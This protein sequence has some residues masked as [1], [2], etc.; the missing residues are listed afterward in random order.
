MNLLTS[1][2]DGFFK[3]LFFLFQKIN[4][5]F[6]KKQKNIWPFNAISK[7]PFNSYLSQ[8][9]TPCRSLS[10]QSPDD[11]FRREN[12]KEEVIIYVSIYS[13]AC[14]GALACVC[15]KPLNIFN[16]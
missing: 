12:N 16:A 4:G 7:L 8:N 5:S 15:I 2:F 11:R 3:Q 10:Q 6:F 9:N 14:L 13:R 1:K